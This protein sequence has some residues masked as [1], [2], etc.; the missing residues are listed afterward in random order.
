VQYKTV[1]SYTAF[2]PF[3]KAETEKMKY[4]TWLFAVVVPTR[5][6]KNTGYGIASVTLNGGIL[7]RTLFTTY[8]E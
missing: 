8:Y 3:R 2:V 5:L 1:I 6:D 7:F 4:F